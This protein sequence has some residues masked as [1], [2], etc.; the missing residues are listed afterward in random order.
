MDKWITKISI[1]KQTGI[2]L[3][4]DHAPE[5]KIMKLFNVGGFPSYVFIDKNGEYKPDAIT[6]NQCTTS[7]ILRMF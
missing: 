7:E 2:H 3:F 6:K 5:Y 1:M 4:V